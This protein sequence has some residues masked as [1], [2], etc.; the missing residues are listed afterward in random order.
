MTHDQ[1]RIQ[2]L[3]AELAGI[4]ASHAIYDQKR[5]NWQ[6]AAAHWQ[7]VAEGLAEALNPFAETAKTADRKTFSCH[8]DYL[9]AVLLGDCRKAIKAIESMQQAE[10]A[11]AEVMR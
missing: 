4:R 8:D 11:V 1:L 2:D 9:V 5:A 3:E 6:A 10:A 7:A